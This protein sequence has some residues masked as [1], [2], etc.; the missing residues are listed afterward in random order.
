T[1]KKFGA[2]YYLKDP[3]LLVSIEW[4]GSNMG[5]NYV[6]LGAEY[7]VFKNLFL[8]GGF[9]RLNLGNSDEP[10]RPA[11]GFSYSRLFGSTVIGFDYAF[12]AEPYSEY[13][14]HIIGLNFNF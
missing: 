8:R 10:L 2:T 11:F 7:E 12:V 13:A 1:I 9:D 3:N 14:S 5:T 6:R 4:E